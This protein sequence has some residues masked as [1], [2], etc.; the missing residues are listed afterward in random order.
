MPFGMYVGREP[1]AEMQEMAP[2]AKIIGIEIDS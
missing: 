2:H 1:I